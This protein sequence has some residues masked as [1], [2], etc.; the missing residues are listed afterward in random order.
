[1]HYAAYKQTKKKG[2]NNAFQNHHKKI[3][4]T[5]R[6]SFPLS[7]KNGQDK[8]GYEKNAQCKRSM[9]SNSQY[10]FL[11]KH[12]AQIPHADHSH[13]T[14]FESHRFIDKKKRDNHN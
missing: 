1:M 3:L 10:D 9:N 12:I 2:I 11:E 8:N 4:Q 7:Q 14:N 13:P 6:Y 5:Q